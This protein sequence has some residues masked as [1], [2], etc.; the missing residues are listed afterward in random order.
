MKKFLLTGLLVVGGLLI[1]WNLLTTDSE[2]VT[3]DQ[4]E[5]VGLEDSDTDSDSEEEEKESIEVEE[6]V[7]QAKNEYNRLLK[8]NNTL[9]V[10]NQEIELSND[11][12]RR[13]IIKTY[14]QTRMSAQEDLEG[15]NLVDVSMEYRQ[16]AQLMKDWA[17]EEY[18]VTIT[19]NEVE[20]FID[21]QISYINDSSESNPFFIKMSNALDISKEEYFY[22][23][24]YD[25]FAQQLLE[26][27]VLKIM[28]ERH[29][30]E[31][32]ESPEAHQER[33]IQKMEEELNEYID[34]HL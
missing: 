7:K 10:N 13:W 15:T 2:D 6:L 28:A 29:P 27:R 11:D 3:A 14:I 25:S 34:E 31:E 16:R 18:Q 8:Q 32:D 19:D 4:D 12:V 9:T 26:D 17:Q 1:T 24:E 33:I 20:N 30:K 23:W 22:E 5:E 21:E